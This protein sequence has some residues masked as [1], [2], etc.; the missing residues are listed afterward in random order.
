VDSSANNDQLNCRFAAT[1]HEVFAMR[2]DLGGHVGAD[3]SEVTIN[4]VN[5]KVNSPRILHYYGVNDG[6]VGLDNNGV[7]PGYDDNTW[8]EAG[9]LNLKYSTMPGLSYDGTSSRSFDIANIT[10][11]GSA[12]ISTNSKGGVSVYSSPALEAF[13][14]SHPDNLVTIFV[15]CDSTSTAQTGMA[16]KDATALQGGDP[17][18]AAG[19]FAPF[20]SFKVANLSAPTLDYVDTGGNLEFSWTG[21]FKLQAQ[22]NNL[23]SG[24]SGSW[25]DYPGGNSSPVSVPIDPTQGTVFFRLTTP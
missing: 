7:T 1:Y 11:L 13:I 17:S 20:L 21:N 18:G 9:G 24:I 16:S 14:E 15:E 5:Y 2:F 8:D 12:V 3:L 6:T 10:D 19:D 22:T 23:D 25:S 4:L